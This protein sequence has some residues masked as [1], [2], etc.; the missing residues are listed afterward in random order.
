M[1]VEIRRNGNVVITIEGVGGANPADVVTVFSNSSISHDV[2]DS[3]F[4]KYLPE[5]RTY[6][7]AYERVESLHENLLGRRK[8]SNYACYRVMRSKKKHR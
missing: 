3:L 6:T 5:S 2:F 8:Y 1:S 4:E 7:E